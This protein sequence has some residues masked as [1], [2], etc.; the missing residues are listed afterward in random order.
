MNSR[1]A[2]GFT[3]VA[4][5]I[6]LVFSVH[7]AAGAETPQMKIKQK[8]GIGNYLADEKG[9]TLYIFM[10]DRKDMNSCAGACLEK[11]P[12]YYGNK[13]RVPRG[14]DHREFGE[15]TR[16]DGRKQTTF[17][18]MPLYYFAE[19]KAPGDTKGQGVNDLWHVINP[20]KTI[21]CK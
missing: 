2:I 9:M 12:I 13:I 10:N 8:D 16:T 3:T 6:V 5:L 19:D 17:K 15:F 1:H 7:A 11:W 4:A 20:K 18:D 21:G 14:T